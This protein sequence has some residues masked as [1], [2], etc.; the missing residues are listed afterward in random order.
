MKKRILAASLL[1]LFVTYT[2][3]GNEPNRPKVI[4]QTTFGDIGLELYADEAP[5]T[6]EN[7]L[8]YV[9]IDFYDGLVFHR[10]ESDFV[11]Q[12][13]GYYYSNGVPLKR[14]DRDPII[15]ESYNNLSN[16][17]GTI[18]MART[19]RPDSA[20]SQ[21]YI[22]V[23]DNGEW[24]DRSQVPDGVGYCVFGQVISGMDV[25]DEIAQTPT[26]DIYGFDFFPFPQIVYLEMAYEAPPGYW[27][28][29]DLNNN[30]IVDFRDFAMF[31]LSFIS[32]SDDLIGD[33]D[34]N[35]QINA[36]DIA[37]LAQNWLQTTDW[38]EE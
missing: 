22:N 34:G 37:L 2:A 38:H 1:L 35:S 26:Q 15:N 31:A 13:G 7:F 20:T 27:I 33:L 5:I 11:I 9:N 17:R 19:N 25:V 10:I 8:M 16:V 36:E 21:F 6:V 28:T 24:L 4:L 30:G 18:G 12:S 29:G 3:I 23:F 32:E 14:P